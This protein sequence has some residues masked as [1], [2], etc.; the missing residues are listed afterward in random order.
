M[1][2]PRGPR[3]CPIVLTSYDKSNP[4]SCALALPLLHAPL[5]PAVA[6]DVSPL[7]SRTISS[8]PDSS[9]LKSSANPT[10]SWFS[11]VGQWAIS[12]RVGCQL[13]SIGRV[14]VVRTLMFRL[15]HLTA[16]GSRASR[17]FVSSQGGD[18]TS[19][20]R[21][22]PGA[23]QCTNSAL[24]FFNLNLVLSY[25]YRCRTSDGGQPVAGRTGQHCRNRRQDQTQVTSQV[26]VQEVQRGFGANF[27]AP[28][29]D[30]LV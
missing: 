19:L 23:A 13:L 29:G 7:L 2:I 10:L 1:H 14:D 5:K 18:C 15:S 30:T 9:L 3:P 24:N 4:L 12:H 25:R 17:C 28:S 20:I 8:P 26:S 21:A 22:R 16:H 27:V 6:L 11:T